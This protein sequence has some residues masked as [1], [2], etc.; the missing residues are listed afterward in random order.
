MLSCML[1]TVLLQDE[2]PKVT[3]DLRRFYIANVYRKF[4]NG[5]MIY[6]ISESFPRNFLTKIYD[7]ISQIRHQLYIISTYI[8]NN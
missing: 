6:L 4:K 5:Y 3:T 1:L 2:I 7:G 8:T